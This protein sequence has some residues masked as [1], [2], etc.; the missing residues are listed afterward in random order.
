MGETE[1]PAAKQGRWGARKRPSSRTTGRLKI[2]MPACNYYNPKFTS[3]IARQLLSLRLVIHGDG[4]YLAT[5]NDNVIKHL[6]KS[7]DCGGA[8]PNRSRG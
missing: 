6:I 3:V 5:T 8:L 2:V 7:G 1:Y 4:G